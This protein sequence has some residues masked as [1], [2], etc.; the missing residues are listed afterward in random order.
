MKKW[1][2]GAIATAPLLM[3]AQSMVHEQSKTYVGPTDPLVIEKLDQ[4]RDLK[5]GIIFHWGLYSVPGMVESWQLTSEDWITPDTTRTY[6]EFKQWYWGLI[7]EFNPAE[8]DPE[9]WARISKQAGAK[10]MVFTSKHHDGFCLFDSKLTDFTVTHSAFAGN[11]KDNVL[12]HVFEAFRNEGLKIGCYY[13]KPDW[14]SPYYWWPAKATPNRL[15]NYNIEQYPERWAAY[16]NYVYE[17]ASELMHDYGPIDI[18]WLDGGWCDAP[19]EDIRLDRIVEMARQAQPGLIVVNRAC[20]GPY[21]DYQTPE[22]KIPDHQITTPWE[23][24]ITLTHDWGWTAHPVYKTPAQIIS[25]LAECVAKG[26]SLLLGI[27]PTPTGII[28][29]DNCER[30][31]AIGRWLESNGEA[32]YGTAI[33]DIYTNDDHTL[34]FTASKDGS[35]I[36]GIVPDPSS[37]TIQW[38]GNTPKRGSKVRNLANGK[39]LKHTTADGLTTLAFMPTDIP[40]AFKI[41]L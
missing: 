14:H 31:M 7:D 17:Q 39:A 8:F 18:F 32:I 15:H 27:G 41:E 5:F 30:L 11:P 19:R 23:S 24:C 36:Y 16:Q 3:A 6:E 1:I 9:Q 40:L 29:E 10:Y 21:E 26:G 34:W 38:Q 25:T 35:A 28:D 12:W 33:T 22:Q 4:W 37:G 20:P 2:I 13:S